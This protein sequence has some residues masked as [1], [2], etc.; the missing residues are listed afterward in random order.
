MSKSFTCKT[1]LQYMYIHCIYQLYERRLRFST[2]KQEQLLKSLSDKYMTDEESDNDN[3]ILI[4]RSPRWR[5]EKLTQL[6]YKLDKKYVRSSKSEKSR[7]L[8]PRRP[9]PHSERKPPTNAP[10]WA[11]ATSES[12]SPESTSTES[13]N[14]VNPINNCNTAT[15]STPYAYQ[16]IFCIT[17]TFTIKLT[18]SDDFTSDRGTINNHHDTATVSTL[19]TNHFISVLL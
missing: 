2:D 12:A 8:K 18:P 16:F 4:R 6:F 7:P 11:I 9:G 15:V 3:G 13:E 19:Y 17:V 10:K 14:P 5:H 1:L